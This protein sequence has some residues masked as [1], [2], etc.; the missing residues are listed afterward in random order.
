MYLRKL[1]TVTHPFFS[2]EYNALYFCLVLRVFDFENKVNCHDSARNWLVKNCPYNEFTI[3]LCY[4]FLLNF[5]VL[6]R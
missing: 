5:D 2:T 3:R 1:Y 4:Y 6:A